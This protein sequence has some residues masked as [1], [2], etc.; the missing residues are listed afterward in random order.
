MLLVKVSGGGEKTTYCLLKMM[1][2]N[3]KLG[4]DLNT[5]NLHPTTPYAS[6]FVTV[7]TAQNHTIAP[8]HP[9]FMGFTFFY[10]P[11]GA[12]VKQKCLHVV[13]FIRKSVT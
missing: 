10:P 4:L 11:R 12:D 6:F 9:A 1:R 7:T 3:G 8:T 13:D 2:A 5:P